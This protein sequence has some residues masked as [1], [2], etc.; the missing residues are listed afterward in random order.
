MRLLRQPQQRLIRRNGKERRG[1]D[2]IAA[3][4]TRGRACCGDRAPRVH[5]EE[6]AANGRLGAGE[7]TACPESTKAYCNLLTCGESR[8]VVLYPRGPAR[9]YTVARSPSRNLELSGGTTPALFSAFLRS[10]P[11]VRRETR[12][13]PPVVVVVVSAEEQRARSGARSA[14]TLATTSEQARLPAEFKHINKRRKRN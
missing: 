11:R 4:A 3:A 12:D 1:G 6:P 9:R 8:V 2:A 5:G 7:P 10:P 14:A 13:A